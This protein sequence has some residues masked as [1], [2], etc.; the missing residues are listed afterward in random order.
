MANK[1]IKNQM[2]RIRNAAAKGK[3]VKSLGSSALRKQANKS[4][5]GGNINRQRR[6]NPPPTTRRASQGT[7]GAGRAMPHFT[8]EDLTGYPAYFADFYDY[9]SQYN[10]CETSCEQYC[11]SHKQECWYGSMALAYSPGDEPCISGWEC[12]TSPFHCPSN[13]DP[14]K[15]QCRCGIVRGSKVRGNIWM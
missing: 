6:N 14:C 1:N 12:N 8:C 7:Q 2:R 15:C 10:S 11:E 9:F 4:S 3:S 13:S 5:T